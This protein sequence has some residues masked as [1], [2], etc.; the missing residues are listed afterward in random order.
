MSTSGAQKRSEVRGGEGGGGAGEG[1]SVL[2]I[3]C[4]RSQTRG[5]SGQGQ[6]PTMVLLGHRRRSTDCMFC[7][8]G[9]A[10][11]QCQL[12]W[13][14]VTF[15]TTAKHNS[16]NCIVRFKAIPS[17]FQNK[18]F[19][20]FFRHKKLLA[21]FYLSLHIFP[22]LFSA[23]LVL[24]FHSL[25]DDPQ[26]VTLASARVIL[27]QVGAHGDRV[28]GVEG[29]QQVLA[30]GAHARVAVLQRAQRVLGQPGQTISWHTPRFKL[31]RAPLESCPNRPQFLETQS[32]YNCKIK[33]FI[34]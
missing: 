34:N 22:H 15:S 16:V 6:R 9:D 2:V 3:L 24:L 1:K 8:Y 28:P 13:V 7:Q 27:W 12:Y 23:L 30:G 19:R 29:E 25:V 32:L 11:L 33:S 14:E 10:C 5:E 17:F 20:F 26:C 4:C 21:T 31:V 18:F